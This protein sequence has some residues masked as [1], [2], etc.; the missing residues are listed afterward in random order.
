MGGGRGE[1]CREGQW[2]GGEGRDVGRGSGRGERGEM[3]GGMVDWGKEREGSGR[4]LRGL[5]SQSRLR[6]CTTRALCGDMVVIYF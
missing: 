1:R 3:E 6:R 2:E 4:G 5:Q